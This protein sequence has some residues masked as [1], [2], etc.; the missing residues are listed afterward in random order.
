MEFFDA[1]APPSRDTTAADDLHEL[2]RLDAEAALQR[3]LSRA[4]D[5]LARFD[6]EDQQAGVP[7]E[8]VALLEAITGAE[9]APLSYASLHRR[10]HS[11]STSWEAFW[12][13]PQDEEDGQRLVYE[14]MRLGTAQLT[15]HMTAHDDPEAPPR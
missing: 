5:V 7:S 14:V 3:A 6:A 8:V 4:D 11:G 10:V 2:S 13:N 1:S 9:Q 12:L 15:T